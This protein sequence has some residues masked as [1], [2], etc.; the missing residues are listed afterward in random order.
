[1]RALKYRELKQ[2]FEAMG[3]KKADE[4]LTE[5]LA[6]KE[7]MPSDF[8]I[9]E[10]AEVFMGHDFVA[11][12]IPGSGQLVTTRLLEQGAGDAVDS[13]AF[14]AIAY[15]VVSS[16]IMQSYEMEGAIATQL[17][18][19]EP[20]IRI[21]HERIPGFTPIGDEA[22][23][24]REGMP[25]QHQDYGVQYQDF[26]DGVKRGMVCNI[27]REAI[28]FDQTGQVLKEAQRLGEWL[29]VNK[30]KRCW[31]VILGIT[32]NYNWNG[33]G[34]N[35]YQNAAPW[36]NIHGQQ[37]VDWQSIDLAERLWDNMTDPNTGEPIVIGGV[38][39]IVMPANY[40]HARRILSATQVYH[41]LQTGATRR[42]VANTISDNPLQGYNL[43]PK[44]RL[45]RARLAGGLGDP[46]EAWLMGDFKK[47][48]VYRENWPITTM[49]A[50]MNSYLEF[51]QDIVMQFKATERGL[52]AV[53]DPR[54]VIVSSGGCDHSS[55]GETECTPEAW[56]FNDP[57]LE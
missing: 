40:A 39:L 26:G 15:R 23:I 24:I 4:H 12:C 22:E 28:H 9:R 6:N 46:D 30:E 45:A 27:T 55:S 56:P 21:R 16:Q 32:N 17:I 3:P 48:F 54:Y 35:T 34:Y 41:G 52:A 19:N 36:I 53:K 14:L 2:L 50:P 31:D 13:T 33:V 5:A 51:H 18:D 25:Y 43:S 29:G 37:L 1:M 47:A 7:L 49:Q 57:N 20:N 11:A 42:D 44:S 38:T 10:L 8:S